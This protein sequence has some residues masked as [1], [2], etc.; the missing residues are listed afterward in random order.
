M[1]DDLQHYRFTCNRLSRRLKEIRELLS[2]ESDR[3]CALWAAALL[4]DKLEE[5]LRAIFLDEKSEVVNLLKGMGPLSSFSSRSKLV[6]VLGILHKSE[7]E[8]CKLIKKI[9]NAFAHESSDIGFEKPPISNWIDSIA[10]RKVIKRES[11]RR[12]EY[13]FSVAFILE[14]IQNRVETI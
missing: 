4:D 10:E 3:G 2:T 13:I 6:Y 9:R 8:E 14:R 1:H 12:D 5:L 7:F 11:N